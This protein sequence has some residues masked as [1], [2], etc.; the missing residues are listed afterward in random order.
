MA[1]VLTE[2][3][4]QKSVNITAFHTPFSPLRVIEWSFYIKN[5]YNLSL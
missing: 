4:I 5:V 1:Y 2:E 3:R